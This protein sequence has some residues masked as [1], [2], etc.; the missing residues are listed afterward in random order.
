MTHFT[1]LP[2]V[3]RIFI[4]AGTFVILAAGF[5]FKR[6]MDGAMP[7]PEE[8]PTAPSPST[9]DEWLIEEL[10]RMD[11]VQVLEVKTDGYAEIFDK[12]YSSFRVEYGPA[13]V[14]IVK[15]EK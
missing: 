14:V 1:A 3:A 9:P 12:D 6:A 11:G 7:D 2:L 15:R 10:Q 13:L 8:S 4:I 5:M